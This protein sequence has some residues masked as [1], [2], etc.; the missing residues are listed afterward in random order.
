MQTQFVSQLTSPNGPRRL[1]FAVLAA[2]C[3]LPFSGCDVA[4][5]ATAVGE[6]LTEP[7]AVLTVNVLRIRRDEQVVKTAVYFGK[8]IPN[9]QTQLSFARAG[10]IKTVFYRVGEKIPQGEKLV[11][12]DQG[13]LE[14]R[15]ASLEDLLE[16]AEQKPEAGDPDPIPDQQTQQVQ[17]LKA[18]LRQVESDLAEGTIVAPYSCIVV[19]NHVESG[20]LVTP[21]NRAVEIIEDVNPLVEASL[22]RKIADALS[23]NQSVWIV[24]G[25]QAVQAQIKTKSPVETPAGSKTIS[26]EISSELDG[27]AWSFGQTVEIRFFMPS[28]SSG[29][30]LP[31]SALHREAG[32]LWSA[33]VAK[34]KSGGANSEPQ[35]NRSS[36]VTRK[37]LELI[38]LEDD[39]VLVQG[40][41]GDGD[42]VIVNGSH[43]VVPGQIVLT[44]DVS[45]QYVR[46]RSS[47]AG[48]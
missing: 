39:W 1:Q 45:S 3:L 43:R 34:P 38:H 15:K 12:L 8:L 47:G 44:K 30:W 37:T 7:A 25:G 10:R 20:A 14:E 17:Q 46:P 48:E 35:N 5:N 32:G 23:I 27:V 16:T 26:L 2:I 31:F 13:L 40:A 41:V 21:Q 29:Y 36:K 6:S 4:S 24:V 28:D 33:L 18:Q 22:P 11:E 19:T 9:R 42:E